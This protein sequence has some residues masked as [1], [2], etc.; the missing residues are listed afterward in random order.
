MRGLV[1]DIVLLPAG[2]RKLPAAE[3]HPPRPRPATNTAVAAR[4]IGSAL[5]MKIR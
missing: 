1:A 3:L 4:L 2:A 5:N